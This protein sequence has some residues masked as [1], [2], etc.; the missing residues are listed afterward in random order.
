V[1]VRRPVVHVRAH[2]D[3]STFPQ[4]A[5]RGTPDEDLVLELHAGAA[6][7]ALHNDLTTPGAAVRI[8]DPG[9]VSLRL[10]DA[11]RR[12]PLYTTEPPPD[13][14]SHVGLLAPSGPGTAP[15]LAALLDFDPAV[16]A[17]T[18]IY[19]CPASLTAAILLSPWTPT[20]EE[21]SE[22]STPAELGSE[23]EWRE[24]ALDTLGPSRYKFLTGRAVARRAALT[25]VVQ[26][27]DP[28]GELRAG[29]LWAAVDAHEMEAR[30]FIAA[31]RA[32]GPGVSVESVNDAS[33]HG[34]LHELL[35][36]CMATG[37]LD[38]DDDDLDPPCLGRR[39]V[40]ADADTAT[41]E[42]SF[43][44]GEPLFSERGPGSGERGGLS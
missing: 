21:R 39:P 28:V 25:E 10:T 22:T 17:Q 8:T 30:A 19:S 33:Q 15:G 18:Q 1:L 26:D 23:C 4:A 2:P 24:L 6:Y 5:V 42:A 16:D 41:A 9:D 31:A 35:K 43:L 36:A 11:P 44:E 7:C 14:V 13:E 27:G 3:V 34:D 20:L 37:F 29:V 38:D 12:A 40:P 32:Q